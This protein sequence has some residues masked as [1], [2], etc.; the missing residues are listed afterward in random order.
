MI[1]LSGDTDC[2]LKINSVF[3]VFVPT[4]RSVSFETTGW[5]SGAWCHDSCRFVTFRV[6]L[7]CFLSFTHVSY[8]VDLSR[9][10]WFC[11]VSWHIVTNQIFG[12]LFCLLILHGLRWTPPPLNSSA[13]ALARVALSSHCRF[14]AFRDIFCGERFFYSFGIYPF[15]GSVSSVRLT[16]VMMLCYDSCFLFPVSSRCL[17]CGLWLTH[18]LHGI[19]RHIKQ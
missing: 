8:V 7:P 15:G 14:V 5:I 6:I 17:R 10:A 16:V 4:K 2:V 18:T 1:Y 12:V 9:F 13:C 19:K 11:H 3:F